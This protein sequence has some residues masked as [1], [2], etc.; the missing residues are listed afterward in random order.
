MPVVVVDYW[1][2]LGAAVF[3]DF[4]R[5]F[6]FGSGS[7]ECARRSGWRLVRGAVSHPGSSRLLQFGLIRS[8]V[9]F[10]VAAEVDGAVAELQLPTPRQT[11]SVRSFPCALACS[12]RQCGRCCARAALKTSRSWVSV[13]TVRDGRG[14][15]SRFGLSDG[16]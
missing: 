2:L 11:F 4:R 15:T 3:V 6:N 13:Q 8:E 7:G 1:V 16:R 5:T 10:C 12:S 9:P 14:V